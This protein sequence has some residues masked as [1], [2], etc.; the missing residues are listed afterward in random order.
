MAATCRFNHAGPA[1][2]YVGGVS[3]VVVRRPPRMPAPELPSGE[4]VLDAPPEIPRAGGRQWT[5]MLMSVPMMAGSGAMALMF[6]GGASGPLRIVVGGLFGLS[7]L[8]MI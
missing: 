2:A 6:T 4:V 5:Q 8:G 3:T 7:A 1:A